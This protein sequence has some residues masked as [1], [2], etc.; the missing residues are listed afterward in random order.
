[1]VSPPTMNTH[2]LSINYFSKNCA[3]S[4]TR[5]GTTQRFSRN[6]KACNIGNGYLAVAMKGNISNWSHQRK[7]N[8][9]AS[10]VPI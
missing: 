7:K 8:K 6:V 10:Y 2:L 4:Y 3:H 5:A 1:M 9:T